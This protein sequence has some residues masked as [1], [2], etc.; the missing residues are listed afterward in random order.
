MDKT[1]R[2]AV[3]QAF[4]IQKAIA[5]AAAPVYF[6]HFFTGNWTSRAISSNGLDD[7]FR[8]AQGATGR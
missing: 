4:E 3:A 5:M 2:A 6:F 7:V 8:A 1:K